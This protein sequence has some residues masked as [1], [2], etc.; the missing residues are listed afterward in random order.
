MQNT[1][2]VFRRIFTEGRSHV[3]VFVVL[4]GI[5]LL[6]V[7]LELY[8]LLLSR[9]VIDEGFLQR[10][11]TVVRSLLVVMFFLFLFRSAIA[12]S[13]GFY[14]ARLQLRINR[15]FQD[16]LFAHLIRLPM[17]VLT[18][19]P[20]GRLMSRILDDG[21]RLSS[22][23]D[24]LFGRGV[25]QP[26]KLG[27]LALVLAAVNLPL[28]GLL[29]VSAAA[30]AGVI[31]WLGNRFDRTSKQ[32]QHKDAAL[33]S[34]VEEMLS[35]LEL[36][37]S[38]AAEDDSAAEF[39]RLL[40]QRI[41][42]SL[43]MQRIT[44]FA[45]PALQLLKFSAVG[46]VLF[47]GSWM[48]AA[49]SISFGTLLMFVGTGLLFFSTLNSVGNTYGRLRENL[50]RLEVVYALLDTAAEHSATGRPRSA[51]MPVESIAF[52]G[53]DFR[54]ADSS[55]LLDSVT[56][57]IEKGEMVG[58]TGQSGSGKTTLI[59]LLL[60]FYDPDAGTVSVNGQSVRD[61]D[62]ATLRASVGIVFQ[63]N[64]ILNDSIR[65]NMAYGLA[66]VSGKK[67]RE[68][69]MLA[70]AHDFIQQLPD[71]YETR[72][73]EKGRRLSGG[74]RQRLAIA[75]ALISDPAVLVLDEATS[76]LEMDREAEILRRIKERRRNQITLVVTHR[77][78]AIRFADRLLHLDN[79]RMVAPGVLSFYKVGESA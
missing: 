77:P 22:V 53:V 33:Y 63:E 47:L 74:Q 61:L 52:T 76:Y 23:Y 58:I 38:K 5:S 57:C 75:R 19:Q 17:P 69:A 41:L 72:V 29:L 8:A 3:P 49:G 78:S 25:L 67:L 55:P 46:A 21:T 4:G 26:V 65:N 44:L 2:A 14:S 60:R 43:H 15:N 24:Q 13:T 59:R 45:R 6:M 27:A 73:G 12:Y 16:R 54:Y 48:V 37:K 68:A 42:L 34:Y 32:I 39:R 18:R 70:G 51:A 1:I 7:P 64:L 62:L 20:V 40:D 79:G 50:A 66:E 10:D 30:A 71:G 36:V 28:F 35:N 56:F 9:R 31:H 11:W